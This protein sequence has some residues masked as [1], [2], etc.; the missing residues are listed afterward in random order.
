MA[1]S[2]MFRHG[3]SRMKIELT[4]REAE[5]VLRTIDA[6]LKN[7]HIGGLAVAEG[8][9]VF[10]SKVNQAKQQEQNEK[11]T[12]PWTSGPDVSD[13]PSALRNASI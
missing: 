3:D 8:M 13:D 9:N 6:G 5:A 10:I 1:Q 4:D 2:G 12:Q 11:T 7:I